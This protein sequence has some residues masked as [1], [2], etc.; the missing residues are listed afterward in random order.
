MPDPTL[1]GLFVVAS[2]VAAA[3]ARPGGALI[4]SRA[5]SSRGGRRGLSRCSASISAPSSIS[6]RRRSG[7]RPS[8]CRRRS[9]SRSSNISAPPISSGSASAPS[10]PRIPIPKRR[11]RRPNRCVASSATVS[12]SISS[13]RRRRSSFSRSCRNSSIPRADALQAQILVLGLTFMG[14]GV[15][16]DAM[17]ALAAGRRRRFRPPQPA[18]PALAALVRR[19]LVRGSRRHGGVRDAKV[20]RIGQRRSIVCLAY[21]SMRKRP[22]RTVWRLCWLTTVTLS[23]IRASSSFAAPSFNCASATQPD[24]PAR[25]SRRCVGGARRAG[26]RDF[27]WRENIDFHFG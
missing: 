6:P 4:S 7:S 17:Y 10:W 21:G 16:S 20:T 11:R 13:T 14:L 18:L 12:W 8:S 9:P 27:P 19:R 2:V 15:M 24:E 25:P 3:D 26:L 23:L 5:R 22:M 1:W